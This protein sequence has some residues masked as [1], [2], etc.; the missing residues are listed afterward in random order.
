MDTQLLR[1]IEFCDKVVLS[2]SKTIQNNFK[3]IPLTKDISVFLHTTSE[4]AL[5]RTEKLLDSTI[6]ILGGDVEEI[7]EGPEEIVVRFVN[8][9]TKL[10]QANFLLMKNTANR[11]IF[12][13]QQPKALTKDIKIWINK[14]YMETSA[15]SIVMK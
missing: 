2:T 12:Y 7:K 6:Q 1:S 15:V 10:I 14:F 4:K 5:I 3:K 8:I 11:A 9:F 13:T